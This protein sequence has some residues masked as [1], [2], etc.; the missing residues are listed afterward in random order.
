MDPSSTFTPDS[1][2]YFANPLKRWCYDNR[3]SARRFA[4]NAKISLSQLPYLLHEDATKLDNVQLRTI[5]KVRTFTG[6]DLA[7]WYIDQ[8]LRGPSA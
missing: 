7:A 3:L 5:L 8:K 1:P 4:T 6:I 2:P